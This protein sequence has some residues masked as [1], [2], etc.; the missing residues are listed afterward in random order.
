LM[1]AVRFNITVKS[2][3]KNPIETYISANPFMASTAK[4]D[5]NVVFELGRRYGFNGRIYSHAIMLSGN[6]LLTENTLKGWA[7]VPQEGNSILSTI[8]AYI[9]QMQLTKGNDVFKKI[10]N[11]LLRKTW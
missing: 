3:L 7:F 9:L 1:H 4:F 6:M 11:D 2:P 8:H 10:Q 5:S